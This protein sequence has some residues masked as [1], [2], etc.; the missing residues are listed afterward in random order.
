MS[1]LTESQ[2][3]QLANAA[4]AASDAWSHK[5]V[6]R[7]I[8]AAEWINCHNIELAAAAALRV[9]S[10]FGHQQWREKCVDAA[11]MHAAFAA[12]AWDRAGTCA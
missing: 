6:G 9:A 4:V 12:S 7:P 2:A 8:T 1:K 3:D 11:D 10:K 5:A